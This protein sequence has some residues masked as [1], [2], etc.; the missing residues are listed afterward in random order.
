[1]NPSRYS[2]PF[3]NR[4]DA[5]ERLAE[6][7]PPPLMR[8]H[9][10][11]LALPRG[12]VPVAAEIVK[13]AEGAVDFDV[14]NVRKLGV[15]GQE[16][17]AMGAIAG[18][19]V[20]VLDRELLARLRIKP[21]Q[22]DA[23]IERETRELARRETL[24]RGDRPAFPIAGRTVIIVDDG[25]ATGSTLLAAVQHAGKNVVA[26]PV[27]ARDSVERL[28]GEADNVIAMCQPEPFRAVGCWYADFSETT[29]DEVKALLG[30]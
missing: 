20:M 16:E 17:F 28:R 3:A 30:G 23:V 24:Y 14:L 27:G 4:R 13:A 11:V 7:L 29:D 21:S 12:G 5:G 1:M 18:G 10:L 2:A 9:P 25:I 22:V 6:L 26:A 8:S 19:G 15:P